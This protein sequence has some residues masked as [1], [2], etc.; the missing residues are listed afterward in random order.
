MAKSEPARARARR[1]QGDA[2]VD[3]ELT[4]GHACM[5]CNPGFMPVHAAEPVVRVRARLEPRLGEIPNTRFVCPGCIDE[6]A[7]AARAQ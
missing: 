4:S 3:F 7:R 6:L 5:L 1:M 2:D